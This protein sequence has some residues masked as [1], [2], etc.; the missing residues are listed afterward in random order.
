MSIRIPVTEGWDSIQTIRRTFKNEMYEHR[1]LKNKERRLHATRTF[2]NSFIEYNKAGLFNE[3]E[4]ENVFKI[5]IS[6]FE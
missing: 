3:R 5:E 4:V 1:L 6:I 2:K